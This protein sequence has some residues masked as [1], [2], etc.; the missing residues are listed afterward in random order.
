[1]KKLTNEN[2]ARVRNREFQEH[3]KILLA[4]N[5]IKKA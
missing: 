5:I 4:K 2:F 1:M 3:H